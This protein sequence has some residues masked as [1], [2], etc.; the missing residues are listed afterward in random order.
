MMKKLRRLP[1]EV[2]E[3]KEN[4]DQNFPGSEPRSTEGKSRGQGWRIMGQRVLDNRFRAR[5]KGD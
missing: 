4:V 2:V 1:T 5:P 3:R